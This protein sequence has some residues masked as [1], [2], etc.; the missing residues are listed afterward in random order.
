MTNEELI[1]TVAAALEKKL[2]TEEVYDETLKVVFEEMKKKAA[3]DHTHNADVITDGT[4]KAIPTK[5]KQTEWDKKVTKE[6]LNA[7]VATFASG[8]AWKGVFDTL[9]ALRA[10]ITQ[11]KEGD[12]VIVIKEPT[13]PKNTLLIY[14]GEPTNAWQTIGE[15][16]VPGVATHDTDGLM[17]KDDKKKLDGLN[18]YTLQPATTDRLGGVRAKAGNAVTIGGDGVIGIDDARTVQTG[19]RDKWNKTATDL[20]NVKSTADSALAKANSNG[21]KIATLEGKFVYLSIEDARSIIN[22]YKA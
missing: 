20:P 15:L 19:E 3:G 8:L 1:M 17:S 9:E 22:K 21:G 14:E 10:K 6:E 5:A 16:F 11:P 4:T 7:A 2:I 18:N 12:F 13:Y